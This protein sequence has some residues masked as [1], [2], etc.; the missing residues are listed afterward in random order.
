MTITMTTINQVTLP[1]R[2]VEALHLHQGSLF[3]VR[4]NNDRIELVPL[5]TTAREFTDVEYAR[6]ENLYQNEKKSAQKVT[7]KTIKNIK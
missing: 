1:K 2:I 4:V 6:L 5:E 7:K 3:D